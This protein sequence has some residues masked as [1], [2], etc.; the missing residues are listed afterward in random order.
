MCWNMINKV[1]VSDVFIKLF[2]ATA[3]VDEFLLLF[4][5]TSRTSLHIFDPFPLVQNYC[6]SCL[7][8]GQLSST[9][10]HM[11]ICDVLTVL[12]EVFCI[13]WYLVFVRL[14]V[15][16]A[17][18]PSRFE[19]PPGPGSLQAPANSRRNLL[20]WRSL[21]LIPLSLEFFLS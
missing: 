7:L 6:L 18:S 13:S 16:C 21:L 17:A 5:G 9:V 20:E 4:I 12:D 8:I 14:F 2:S 11:I 19:E 15:F 10:I 3:E 1:Y